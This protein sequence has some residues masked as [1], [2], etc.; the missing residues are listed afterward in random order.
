[1][2]RVQKRG[3]TAE[4]ISQRMQSKKEWTGSSNTFE[5]TVQNKQNKLDNAV[6]EVISILEKEGMIDKTN[7]NS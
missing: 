1:M 5:F 2:S 7:E 3:D 6:A 4:S